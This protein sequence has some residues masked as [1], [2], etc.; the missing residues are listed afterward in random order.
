MSVVTR[1][2]FSTK[3]VIREYYETRGQTTVEAYNYATWL[4]AAPKYGNPFSLHT[5]LDSVNQTWLEEASETLR[6][7]DYIIIQE[8]R[9]TKCFKDQL[10]PLM[11]LVNIEPKNKVNDGRYAYNCK[12]DICQIHCKG[13]VGDWRKNETSETY[14][15]V[16]ERNKYDIELYKWARRIWDSDCWL[17][18]FATKKEW[19]NEKSVKEQVALDYARRQ[20]SMNRRKK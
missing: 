18:D 17:L 10:L 15:M 3:S 11:G 13:G 9:N 12:P 8:E 16:E 4:F 6:S 5:K 7:Y 2:D 1:A 20:K 14:G 19:Y